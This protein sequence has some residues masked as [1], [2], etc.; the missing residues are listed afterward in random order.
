MLLF[1]VAIK[2][3]FISWICQTKTVDI[4]NGLGSQS[5]S[6]GVAIYSHNAGNG[7]AKWIQ[8][9][10]T[11]VSLYFM[12]DEKLGV[13]SNRSRIVFKD[14]DA[15]ISFACLFTYEIS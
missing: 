10:R 11:V 4:S 6:Y 13:E 15:D 9:R 2:R 8:G 7:A 5:E 14:R 1:F 3:S 12:S